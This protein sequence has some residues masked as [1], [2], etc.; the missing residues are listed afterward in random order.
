MG[1][2]DKDHGTKKF[3]N[4]F[5]GLQHEPLSIYQVSKK[6]FER[7]LHKTNQHDPQ[8]HNWFKIYCE[9]VDQKFY[10]LLLFLNG[11]GDRLAKLFKAGFY[12]VSSNDD[13]SRSFLPPN[14][15][16]IKIF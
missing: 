2:H 9:N 16:L 3:G 5:I 6:R 8:Q 10:T 1:G 13:F 12:S 7:Y 4:I 14:F 11:S 15:E